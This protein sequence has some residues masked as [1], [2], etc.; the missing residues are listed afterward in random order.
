M[1]ACTSTLRRRLVGSVA[2]VLC[3][4]AS[5]AGAAHAAKRD[6]QPPSQP[7]N[8]HA[9]SATASSV[10]FAWSASTDNVG[11]NGYDVSV[12][13]SSPIRV[14]A[15]SDTA[16]G[17][18][19]GSSVTVNVVAVDRAGNRSTPATATAA[20]SACPTA[21]TTAPSTPTGLSV[22]SA[23]QNGITLNWTA[24]TDDVGVGG[25]DVYQGSTLVAR[26]SASST[27]YAFAN[28]SCGT[29]YT[30]SV[31]AYDAAG[32]QSPRATINASTAA[33]P[34]P[35]DATAP[36]VPGN[37]H[38]TATTA[39]SLTLGWTASTDNVGVAG[40][41]IYNGV[42]RIDTTSVTSYTV[43]N[44]ACGTGYTLAVDAYDAAANRSTTAV[45]N[46]STAACATGEPAAIAGQGYRQVFG[47]EF[48]SLDRSVWDDHI[49]YDGTPN[50]TWTTFQT[51]HD[52]ELD[53]TSSRN[54]FW[55]T[56]STCNW[57][58]NTVTTLSSGKTYQYGYFEARM[59]WTGAKGSWPAFWLYSYQH[60]IDTD[61]CAHQA[62]EIDV[63]EGQGVEPNVFYG[64]VHSNT[65]GCSP[66]DQ[67]NG[68]NWQPVAANLTTGFHTYG[69]L[70]TS[71][72]VTWYLDDKKIMSAPTYATDN[73]PMY[74][75]LQMWIGGWSPDPDSTT[76]N[77]LHTEVDWVH[78][79]QK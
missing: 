20:A 74:L 13:S 2:L 60:S 38:V 69:A 40:Y 1:N 73:Q 29:A 49:W 30:L 54:Y 44:L 47:D 18:V 16:A 75:L 11:V 52:G 64:T 37:V 12:G 61:Q 26:T 67:Q 24:S 35:P 43:T 42:T 22:P 78:V 3:A 14:T 25:Y 5:L 27:S 65:N 51:V 66:S 57:P 58:I 71:T 10:T 41:G 33:C 15:L 28:V 72:S 68:N 4:A 32:N 23:T 39:G 50:P 31:D 48:G 53:L 45:V 9:A 62:G 7:A 8:L 19:C 77:Y 79:W 34:P 17:L 70:W 21:D 59:K 55:S 36:T 63:M 6:R 56:C 46:A 76:P